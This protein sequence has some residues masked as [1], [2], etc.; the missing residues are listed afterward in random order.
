[1]SANGRDDT[2]NNCR[3]RN[4]Q[5]LCQFVPVHGEHAGGI[6]SVVDV[7]RRELSVLQKED[8]T[9]GFARI[10]VESD[11]EREHGWI[12]AAGLKYP[13]YTS[14]DAHLT[15]IG[16]DQNPRLRP[17][18]RFSYS[19]HVGYKV[20]RDMRVIG[21]TDGYRFGESPSVPVTTRGVPQGE[22]YQ[23]ASTLRVFG[24]R[25]EHNFR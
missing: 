11:T 16:F 10:G 6:G 9:I 15:D 24:I 8:Y 7:W 21:Y 14:E 3:E 12:V 1:M 20:S 18:K 13:F 25:L 2:A 5:R 4:A 17:G 23:P 19:A 22:V